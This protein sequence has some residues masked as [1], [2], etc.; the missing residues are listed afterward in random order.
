MEIV[1]VRLIETK[2]GEKIATQII[3]NREKANAL[4]QELLKL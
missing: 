3:A 2:E 4:F 1:I